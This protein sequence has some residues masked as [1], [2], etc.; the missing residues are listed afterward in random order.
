MTGWTIAP[1]HRIRVRGEDLVVEADDDQSRL[2]HALRRHLTI[3]DSAVWLGDQRFGGIGGDGND[4][5]VRALTAFQA[6]FLADNDVPLALPTVPD[7]QPRTDL[8]THFAAALTGRTLVSLGAAAGLT[9]PATM[10][11]DVGV[12]AGGD[13]DVADLDDAA[14]ARLARALDVPWDRQITFAMMERL[15]ARRSVFT[16]NG[17]LFAALLRATAEALAD[18]G[19]VYAELSL[20]TCLEPSNLATLHAELDALEA[21]TGTR[22]RF[23]VALSRH[24][25]LEW[26]LDVLDRL[27]QCLDSDAIV[28][29]DV[30]GHETCSTRAFLPVLER[31]AH[32]AARRPGFVVRVHAG[33]NPAFPENVRVAVETLAPAVREH[34]LQARIGHGLYGV[35]D[36]TLVLL[37]DLPGVLVEFNLTSNLALN[38]I[39]TT[40]QVPLRRYVEAGVRVV[41]GTD[42]AGLYGTCAA[43][44]VRAAAVMGLSDRH[45]EA[46]RTVEDTVLARRRAIP[47][48]RPLSSWRPPPPAAPRHFS[49]AVAAR[50]RDDD[51]ARR[52]AQDL[53]ARAAGRPLVVGAP[54]GDVHGLPVLWLAG[55]WRD[56]IRAWSPGDVAHAVG[57][58]DAVIAGLAVRQGFLVTGGTSL[59]IEG[60]AH[61]LAARHDVRIVGAIVEHTAPAALDPRVHTFWRCART[62]HDKAAPLVQWVRDVAGLGLFVGGG[63]VVA[64]EQ[65]AAHNLGVRHVVLS[66]LPGPAAAAARA[67]RHVRFVENANDVLAALDDRRPRG[68]LRH[69]G[70]NDCADVVV[71][72]RGPTGVE[73]V[74]LIRRHDDAGAA[75]GRFALPGGFVQPGETPAAA[76][77]RELREETGLSLPA[78]VLVPITIV[79]GGGRDPRDTDERWVRSHVFAARVDHDV[80]V[81]GGSDAAAAVF[82]DVRLRPALAFDHDVLVERARDVLG[83]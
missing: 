1:G 57:V 72:R 48:A 52:A 22:L 78:D 40:A 25:D 5:Q 62:L 2:R 51:D 77:A 79:E 36:K 81:R 60:L 49:A 43:D 27:E 64:D 82:V 14:R 75:A 44:E 28:G 55:A 21:Q 63:L 66:G 32:L 30:M 15:Y 11:A 29:I 3:H 50:R 71:L 45:L 39:Q 69:H 47:A 80:L 26:D 46:L 13:V 16:K 18:D 53:L 7:W 56:A 9:I 65:Q 31:A 20:S 67:S 83:R 38:N 24:D 23:L 74:L 17:A 58:L 4:G 35:D 68:R 42:G 73:Q 12:D 70:P 19:V 76:A 10:L 6:R 33:E 34:G 59:G 41:L 54:P 61:G 8:H 37:T